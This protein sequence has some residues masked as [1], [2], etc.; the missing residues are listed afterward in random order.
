MKTKQK[1]INMLRIK[2]ISEWL[3]RLRTYH[4]IIQSQSSVESSRHRRNVGHGRAFLS[5][6]KIRQKKLTILINTPKN[7]LSVPRIRVALFLQILYSILPDKYI[8][9]YNINGLEYIMYLTF[10][11]RI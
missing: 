10:Y 5:A 7:Q 4:Q 3:H 1:T 11:V 9:V 8:S 2:L 6:A